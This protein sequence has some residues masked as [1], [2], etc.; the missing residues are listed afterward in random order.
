[1]FARPT[2]VV[3]PASNSFKRNKVVPAGATVG[4]QSNPDDGDGNG[5]GD[6]DLLPAIDLEAKTPDD[7]PELILAKRMLLRMLWDIEGTGPSVSLDLFGQSVPV[8]NEI[9]R[10]D[11]LI[12][13]YS[14]NPDGSEVP[15]EWVCD[16][17]SLDLR[18]I[19]RIIGRSVRADLVRLVR[20][21]STIVGP[22][23]ASFCE[24]VLSDYAEI[25]HWKLN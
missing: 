16:Q 25:S 19:R 18:R 7:T 24:E 12:W 2:D 1:M 10:F 15:V 6:D 5:D 3:I 13:L 9:D 11:A 8:G 22:A 14:L 17:L 21:L 4:Q 23:H 20:L